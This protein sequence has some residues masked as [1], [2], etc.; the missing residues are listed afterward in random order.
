M[1]SECS[2][3]DEWMQCIWYVNA[4]YMMIECSVYDEWMQCIWWVNA[5]SVRC[6]YE[7]SVCMENVGWM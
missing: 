6:K 1:I 4:V 7:C 2:V 5:V 3:Y